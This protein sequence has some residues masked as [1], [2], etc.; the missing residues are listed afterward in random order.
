MLQFNRGFRVYI[1][2]RLNI[3]GRSIADIRCIS[4]NGRGDLLSKSLS[5][6]SVELLPSSI[7][8]GDILCLYDSF[9]TVYYQG[10]INRLSTNSIECYQINYLFND[11]WKYNITANNIL[12]ET[13]KSII[14]NDFINSTDPIIN[15]I[16]GSF[17]ISTISQTMQSLPTQEANYVVN[18][19]DFLIDIFDKYGI[20]LYFYIPF[21]EDT[22]TIQIGI[23]QL[24]RIKLGD[25][26]VS[27]R[28]IKPITE[29][30][31]TNKLVIYSSD[32]TY[33]ETWYS[34][35]SGITNNP[36]DLS[37]LSKIK[38]AIIFSDD[39][40]SVIIGQNLREQIYN[41]KL[42]L[43]LIL[44]N[45][46]Y[47][48]NEFNLGQLFDVWYLGEYFNTILTGYELNKSENGMMDIVHLVFG[49]VRLRLENKKRLL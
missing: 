22:P 42:E 35:T 45:K 14:S 32:G 21:H 17:D 39:L 18:F 49:K 15:K 3:Q 33:R 7:N 30:Y 43:D 36:N 5:T 25:N 37:R 44:E 19:Q 24:P 2:D 46:L 38:T 8:E 47:D 29:I 10:V 23:K 11:L 26:A 34:G 12:E 13:V 48:F 4:F 16:F 20:Q 40:V 41:H 1:K 31:E 9:G 6:F 28:N 27:I